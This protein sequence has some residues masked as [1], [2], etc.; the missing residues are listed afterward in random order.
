V[1][2]DQFIDVRGNIREIRVLG[3]GC[4]GRR[5]PGGRI[6][7]FQIDQV[8]IRSFNPPPW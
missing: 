3:D 2:V 5:A 7:L 4:V 6:V 8:T 1:D